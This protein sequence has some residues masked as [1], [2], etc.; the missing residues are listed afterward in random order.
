MWIVAC[1]FLAQ[2]ATLG[3]FSLL[4]L[5]GTNDTLMN[6]ILTAV[7]YVVMLAI[8]FGGAYAVREIY[9][10]PKIK[11]L[12]GFTRRINWKDLGQGL[13][14]VALY[15][16]VLVVVMIVFQMLFPDLAGEEQSVGYSKTGNDFWQLSLIFFALV[17]VAPVAEELIM[18]GLL[19]GR[20]RS[21]IPFWPTTIMVSLLFALAHG[22]INV[23]IDVFILSLFL[24]Y[25]REKSGAIYAPILMH[26]IKNLLGFLTVFVLVL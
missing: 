19:F 12:A 17:I 11:E 9:K 20:L 26:S 10:L 15:F 2:Y 7:V 1:Y 5:T 6:T 14:Y 18:R 25:V 23:G 3:I 16:C 13:V 21:K 22:Q 24:C 8:S 4:G